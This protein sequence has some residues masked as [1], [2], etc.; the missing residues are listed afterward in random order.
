MLKLLRRYCRPAYVL[1]SIALI[2]LQVFFDMRL[3]GYMSTITTLIVSK[4]SAM[5]A[6]FAAGGKMLLCALGSA[7]VAVATGYLA[8]KLASQFSH[9]VRAA[10]FEK[11][12]A[13]GAAEMKKFSVSSLITRTTNDITQLQ[14]VVAM[15]LAVIIK[16]PILSVWAIISILGKSWELSC[17][18]AAAVALLLV[19]I[20]VVLAAVLPKFRILQTQVDDLNRVT[21][22]SL[23]GLRVIRAFH[24]QAYQADKFED[25]S[26][27]LMR[28]HLFTMRTM[29][30]VMPLISL[31][32]SGLSLAIYYVGAHLIEAVADY[33][34]RVAMM[35][36]VVVF[37]TYAMFVVMGF[38]L[39]AVIFVFLPRAQVSAN[40]ICE[41][42]DAPIGVQ[43]G[44]GVGETAA[45]G[46]LEFRNVSFRFPESG[47]DFLKNITFSA[48]QGET[49]AI[50]GATGS[51]KTTL[52]SLA[53]RLYDA[54]EGEILLNGTPIRDFS[55]R[56]LYSI[57]GYIPQKSVLFSD[58]I[59]GNVSF[60][61][62]DRSDDDLRRC[63]NVAQARGFV[64]KQD[65]QLE[66]L[67]AQS[68]SNVSGG[69]RQRLAI[70]R[71]L[72]KNPELLIFDDSFSALDFDTDRRLRDALA[73]EY[74]N[75]TRLVVASR[76]GTVRYADRIL[77]LH[78]G[79]LVGNGTHDTLMADCPIYREIALSQL[80]EE[81]L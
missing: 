3:P 44:Q 19:T 49:V 35:G 45:H 52:V 66:H 63:L 20:V 48:K 15:G 56:E 81:A 77:V 21:D 39:L 12:S 65:G 18:V 67:I 13:F 78:D 17:V 73:R 33:S 42:L 41:V 75:T 25:V 7:A 60:G 53:A 72:V 1:G 34:A 22:E 37:T 8:A 50:V 68:G 26:V 2:L 59:R 9:G 29:A 62:P 64:E 69:Q 28:T 80:P 51:G 54:T 61:Q 58:T 43:E 55:F 74:P 79:C 14:M 40:R 46:T 57:V 4:D 23:T 47:A 5:G 32:M 10:V 27:A 36:D 38:M 16:A 24:A 71:A 31:M 11:I 76:I 30:I 70:A 6:I